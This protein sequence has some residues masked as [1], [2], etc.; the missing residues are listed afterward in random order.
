MLFKFLS[1]EAVRLLKLLVEGKGDSLN[2]LL[3]F[4]GLVTGFMSQ[5]ANWRSQVLYKETDLTLLAQAEK[6]GSED[7][8]RK[9]E[10]YRY[11]CGTHRYRGRA[12]DEINGLIYY[13]HLPTA[14]ADQISVGP[15]DLNPFGERGCGLSARS[16]RSVGVYEAELAR[17]FSRVYPPIYQRDNL[18][19]LKWHIRFARDGIRAC[20]RELTRCEL[21][22][23][24]KR[25]PITDR[26]KYLLE[27]QTELAETQRQ[28]KE[29]RSDHSIPPT[30]LVNGPFAFQE[31]IPFGSTFGA[32]HGYEGFAYLPEFLGDPLI[33][34]EG[35]IAKF[36]P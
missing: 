5:I 13:R 9:K 29:A 23:P 35:G 25:G 19:T 30:P 27:H 6:I 36:K 21:Y 4:G 32:T 17:N 18:N 2:L 34:R 22:S 16:Y 11:T 14:V 15:L 24:E 20:K 28:L 7:P 26:A 3:A 33:T 12:V 10:I 1:S 8:R 31:A